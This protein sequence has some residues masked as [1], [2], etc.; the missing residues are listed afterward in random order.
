MLIDGLADAAEQLLDTQLDEN[1]LRSF[2]V[3]LEELLAWNTHTNLTAITEP[4]EVITRHFLDSLT[5][6]SAIGKVDDSLRLADIGTGAGF[7]GLPLKIACPRL[8]LT[9]VDATG[10]K[11]EFLEHLTARLNLTGVTCLQLRAEDM[12]QMPAYR[13]SFDWVVGR[14]VAHLRVL[15]EYLLPLC[16]V[17]GHCLAQKGEGAEIEAEDAQQAFTTLGGTL[18]RI[19]PVKL[20]GLSSPH[21]LV[22]IRKIAA[23]P[24]K[25]PRRA[26]MPTKRPL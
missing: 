15:A 2:E 26:G 12:G 22:V 14:A 10:K 11:V 20:P 19:L 6:L 5:C 24:A 1:Q 8:D 23:T 16:R 18:E 17:G 7:P 4:E 21:H 9:L 13:E 3:Y 25:Y